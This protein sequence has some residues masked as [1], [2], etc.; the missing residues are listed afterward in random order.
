MII[1]KKNN[2]TAILCN[3]IVILIKNM[4]VLTVYKK[5]EFDALLKYTL[6]SS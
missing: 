4:L 3:F 6:I 2:E 1:K 5:F